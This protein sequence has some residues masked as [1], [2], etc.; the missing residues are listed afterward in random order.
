MEHYRLS[1]IVPRDGEFEAL[2]ELLY[3]PDMDAAL[4]ELIRDDLCL[5]GDSAHAGSASE[6]VLLSIDGVTEPMVR[7]IVEARREF[8]LTGRELERIIPGTRREL[9]DA[10]R[11]E[12]VNLIEITVR[13]VSPPGPVY[14]GLTA[15][16]DRGVAA[17]GLKL[18]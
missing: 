10:L 5:T 9:R 17:M 14:R 12:P 11:A 18:D 1:G 8:R 4:F 16:G 13:R 6:A 15:L 3:L 7:S 2:E